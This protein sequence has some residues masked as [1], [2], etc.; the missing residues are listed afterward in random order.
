MKNKLLFIA[1]IFFVLGYLTTSF[2]NNNQASQAGNINI[3]SPTPSLNSL[4]SLGKVKFQD[5][6]LMYLVNNNGIHFYPFENTQPANFA[7]ISIKKKEYPKLFLQ[8][9]ANFSFITVDE[10]K[11]SA[12]NK[13]YLMISNNIP[14]HGGYVST[15][16]LLVNPSTGEVREVKDSDLGK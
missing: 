8:G 15:Y 13:S 12:D 7:D 1:A 3:P 2:V 11:D 4:G 16:S 14:D 6:Q 9:T 5:K 10:Y